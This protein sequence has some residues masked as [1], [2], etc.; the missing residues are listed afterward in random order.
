MEISVKEVEYLSHLARLELTSE[1][2]SRLVGELNK[3]LAHV[4]KLKEVDVE[5]IPPTSHVLKLANVFRE[6]EVLSSLPT[7]KVLANAPS[8][9]GPFFKVPRIIDAAS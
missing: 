9:E 3:I 4:E 7:E 8:K 1:E 6:D 5:G 2:L